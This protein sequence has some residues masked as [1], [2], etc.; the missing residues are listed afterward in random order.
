LVNVIFDKFLQLQ[1]H[2][3]CASCHSNCQCTVT[4]FQTVSTLQPPLASTQ[5]QVLA[6]TESTN[7]M[8]CSVT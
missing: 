2:Y 1:V 7:K 8:H 5:F 6:A 3:T 4:R